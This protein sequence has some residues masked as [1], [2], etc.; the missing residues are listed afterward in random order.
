LSVAAFFHVAFSSRLLRHIPLDF[1]WFPL[2]PGGATRHDCDMA[3]D[4]FISTSFSDLIDQLAGIPEAADILWHHA[5]N[6]LATN[7]NAGPMVDLLRRH[8]APPAYYCDVLA[9]LFDPAKTDYG[10][11]SFKKSKAFRDLAEK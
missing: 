9:D 4:D 3:D 5:W 1:Q 10:Q 2:T 6:A 8:I 7:E 11:L